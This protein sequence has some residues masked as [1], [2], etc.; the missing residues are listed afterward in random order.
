MYDEI[1]VI[2]EGALEETATFHDETL[3]HEYLS[4]LAAELAGD[5]VEYAVYRLTH[6]HQETEE[7][8]CVQFETSHL[9]LFTNETAADWLGE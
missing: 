4:A 7:C 5:G 6:D 2:V 3:E 1:T 8:E 9:P